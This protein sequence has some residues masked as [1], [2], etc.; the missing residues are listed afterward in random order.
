[1]NAAVVP[2]RDWL[3]HALATMYRDLPG[4]TRTGSLSGLTRGQGSVNMTTTDILTGRG[5][6]SGHRAKHCLDDSACALNTST[7]TGST[8]AARS[9]SALVVERV[10]PI[11]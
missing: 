11:T 7:T 4:F 1:M 2:L 9:P 3:L 8:P 6:S 10:V 5:R